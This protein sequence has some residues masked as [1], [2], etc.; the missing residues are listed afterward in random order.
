M[1]LFVLLRPQGCCLFKS[2]KTS[3]AGSLVVDSVEGRQ[4]GSWTPVPEDDYSDCRGSHSFLPPEAITQE[5]Q[6]KDRILEN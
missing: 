5:A 2:F 3:E 4:N 1:T 6:V